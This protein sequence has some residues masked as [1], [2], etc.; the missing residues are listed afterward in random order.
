MIDMHGIVYAFHAFPELGPLQSPRTAASLPFCGR[1]RLIDFSLSAMMNAGIRDVGIIMQRD[2]QSLLDHL[3]SGKEWDLSRRDGGLRLLPPFGMP[4]SRLGEYRGCMEA[5]SAVRPYLSDIR[6]KYVLLTRG[7]LLANIDLT[8]AYES[9]VRSGAEIT[10]L[11]TDSIPE[12]RHH[13]YLLNNDGAA[14]DILCMQNENTGGVTGM[15][16]YIVNKNTLLELV[17]YSCAHRLLYF[18]RDA[19][20]H[21]FSCGGTMNVFMH[22]GYSRHV[23]TVKEYFQS[24][25]D[26]LHSEV[27]NDLFSPSRPVR[28]REHA[29][30]STYYAETAVTKNCLIADGCHI[31]GNLENCIIFRGTSIAS[32][33][34]LKNC[35]IMQNTV[36]G[37]GAKLTNL[38]SDK[39]VIITEDM[40]LAGSCELPLIVPK[41]TRL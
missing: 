26:M 23:G 1:Y 2:Y 33:A 38:I 3:R 15:E 14:V 37:K 20:K 12:S 39:D 5:L 16:A 18:H 36:V 27:R 25:M 21:F 24:N 29:D 34:V 31:D 8:A 11:C 22:Y 30:V 19:V 28:T 7:N 13:R 32:G 17:D 4:S 9:H 40:T 10:T 41:G 35:V 6:Q